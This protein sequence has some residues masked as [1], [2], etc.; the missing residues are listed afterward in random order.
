YPMA[1]MPGYPVPMAYGGAPWGPYGPPPYGMQWGPPGDYSQ[2]SRAIKSDR[3]DRRGRDGRGG[4]D[5]GA[6]NGRDSRDEREKGAK[7]MPGRGRNPDLEAEK[8][9]G[10]PLARNYSEHDD[11]RNDA[12]PA[13]RRGGSPGGKWK[14][15]MFEQL[16]GDKK[17]D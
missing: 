5:F 10:V 11:R 7:W 12:A 3:R 8:L 17:D 4:M 13:V 9:T 1:Y 2:T 6:F 15:D 14:N 16:S